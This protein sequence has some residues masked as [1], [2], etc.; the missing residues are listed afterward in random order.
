MTWQICN[1]FLYETITH[2]LFPIHDV[3]Q[4][5]E[6]KNAFPLRF[7][8]L[9]EDTTLILIYSQ[10]LKIG[11][12]LKLTGFMIQVLPGVLLNSSTKR[13]YSL[14]SAKVQ[15]KK[16][17][18]DASIRPTSLS[19]FFRCLLR[20]FTMRFLRVSW[21]IRHRTPNTILH[22][23]DCLIMLLEIPVYSSKA[24]LNDTASPHNGCGSGLSLHVP[25]GKSDQNSPWASPHH[26]S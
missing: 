15:G 20:F 14:G 2:Y 12:V 11:G 4:F 17:H 19:R 5:P 24:L 25:P 6:E 22:F 23:H 1:Q 3:F 18:L 13:W 26:T 7:C 10:V 9:N 21:N 8:Y 16:S